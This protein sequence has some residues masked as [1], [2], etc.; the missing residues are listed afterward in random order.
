MTRMITSLLLIAVLAVG[1]VAAEFETVLNEIKSYDYGDSRENLTTLTD[2]LRQA[3]EDA[4]QLAEYEAAMLEVLS[5]KE[6]TF[7]AKQFLCK[8]LSIMGT[9]QS[10]D[11]LYDLLMSKNAKH[12]DIA[13]YAL[14]RIPGQA[15]DEALLKALKKTK[16][17]IKVGVINTI[18][19]RQIEE[20]TKPLSK[21][22]THKDD[23]IAM[24]AAAAL[25][26]IATDATATA[27]G[28][29]MTDTDG[30]V[31]ETAVDAYLKNADALFKAGEQNKALA[32]YESLYVP[33]ESI[34]TRSAALTGLVKTVEDPTDLIVNVLESDA[35]DELKAVAISI[36]HQCQR[37]L[38][39]EA[40]ADL[41]P[42]LDPLEQIQLLTAFKV[43]GATQ[44]RDAV[45][46]MVDSEN[47]D[48]R[49]TAME[50]LVT[51]GDESDALLLANIAATSTGEAKETAKESLS[52]LSAPGV[53]Q[54]IVQAIPNAD[55]NVKVELVES[56]GARQ[57]TDAVPTLLTAAKDENVR[58]RVAALKSLGQ[59]ASPEHLPDLVDLLVHAQNN[60]ERREA[61]R[62]VVTVANTIEEKEKRGDVIMVVLPET[63]NM[64]AKSSLMLALGRI[65]D[66]DA[67]PIMRDALTSDDAE[68]KRAAILSLSEW[69]TPEPADDLL[70]V[71]QNAE[72]S[73][74]QVLAL[75]GYIRL[76]GLESDRPKAETVEMYK[77]ALELAENVGEQRMALSGLAEVGS[78]GAMTLAAEYLDHSNLQGEA[79]IAVVSNAW[80]T[81][82]EE[83]AER[84]ALLKRVYDQTSDE[85]VKREAGR[86][87]DQ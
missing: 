16:G 78:V 58:V 35:A 21:L 60:A 18:G 50:A 48:V 49:L 71:T 8:E 33:D 4:A 12:A 17:T 43:R 27:L 67:L 57:M 59:V 52:R 83:S 41:L 36:V 75:R 11:V 26:K 79:E 23:A 44:V 51:V 70:N 38:N 69:P 42:T 32:I 14:E 15:V 22:T 20:A 81:R 7:A 66:P 28:A 80:R 29:A 2:M 39:V 61:E 19:E 13:R 31:R 30:D 53:N 73:S 54:T 45:A 77:T 1:A 55:E 9:E 72:S 63:E 24:A 62:T 3:S 56:V 47:L 86:L 87:L 40:I 25:G 5:D 76:A 74:H 6:T 46:Q 65:G 10:V 85:R 37:D 82:G 34:P 64:T 68:L 84:T